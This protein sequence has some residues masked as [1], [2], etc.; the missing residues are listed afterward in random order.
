MSRSSLALVAVIAA[1]VGALAMFYFSPNNTMF[2]S[3]SSAMNESDVRQIVEQMMAE[4]EADVETVAAVAVAGSGISQEEI[5]PLIENYLMADPK[6]LQRV[7]NALQEQLR[8]EE[9]E[10]ARVGLAAFAKEIYEE[11]GDEVVGNPDG[12]V[13]LVEFFD[14][15]CVYCRRA[16][17]D[18]VQL[19]AE[20]PNLRVVLKEFPILSEASVDAARIGVAVA[21]TEGADYWTFH[22]TLYTVRGQ[23]DKE[24]ALAAAE[25]IGL[26]RVS[27]ELDSQSQSVTDTLQNAYS[28]AQSLNITGTPA[29]IIGDQ[30]IPGAV[31]VDA[32]REA[33][34]N[35]RECGSTNCGA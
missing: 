18:V 22:E 17:P 12:D 8:L 26:N 4:Q 6:I 27:I 3:T 13:T 19:M 23:I 2:A 20:D 33:I 14:Y 10:A 28:L 30:I 15:N 11:P 9:I 16:M 35:V 34:S 32:L 1:L 7:S 31:G 24:A 5:N 29:F 25:K 21:N